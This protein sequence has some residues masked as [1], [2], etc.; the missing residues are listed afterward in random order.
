MLDEHAH[1]GQLDRLADID[2]RRPARLIFCRVVAAIHDVEAIGRLRA[3]DQ[4]AARALFERFVHRLTALAGTRLSGKLRRKV[5]A[6]STEGRMSAYILTAVP[7]LLFT[8]IMV[9]MPQFYR[10][11]WGIPKTWYMLGGSILW[12]LLGN[13]IMFKMSNFRF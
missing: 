9:L 4:D 5:R 12:L 7:V 3:G 8:A 6:I 2:S 1:F 11:V 13:A 10:E